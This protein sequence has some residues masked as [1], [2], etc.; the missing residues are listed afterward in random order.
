MDIVIYTER[1]HLLIIMN[2]ENSKSK[3]ENIKT[4]EELTQLLVEIEK[5]IVGDIERS[6]EIADNFSREST[7]SK[8]QGEA[9]NLE[10]KVEAVETS[11]VPGFLSVDL[12]KQRWEFKNPIVL[13]KENWMG[14]KTEGI[15]LDKG[16]YRI[17]YTA[18]VAGSKGTGLAF[19]NEETKK[20]EK[21]LSWQF[22]S[23]GSIINAS[24]TQYLAVNSSGIINIT[25]TEGNFNPRD[26]Q[27]IYIVT[28]F[29][30]NTLPD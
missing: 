4:E 12:E 25:D 28:L 17:E 20:V 14:A 26:V 3:A 6:I 9:D 30:V 22:S 5:N 15:N 1:T 10:D 27:S 18:T 11:L 16:I 21:L 7:S 23:G 29:R 19:F 8:D 13:F 24:G 2:L